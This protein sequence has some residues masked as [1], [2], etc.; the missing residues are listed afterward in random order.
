MNDT[1]AAK[2]VELPIRRMKDMKQIRMYSN[3]T[4]I[5]FLSLLSPLTFAATINVPADQPTIQSGIDAAQNGDTVLVGDG[6]YRGEGN[7]NLDF[8]G[9]EITLKSRNGAEDTI[10]DCE[11][12]FET[13]GFYFHNGETY[14]SV[15]DGFTITNG[16]HDFGGAIALISASPTIK[17]CVVKDNLTSGIHCIN[18]DLS[19]TDSIISRNSWYRCSH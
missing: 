17:N 9:K 14:E 1:K 11:K 16:L 15:L 2:T 7:V 12:K 19:I 13:R 3:L 4:F 10:I 18:S 8:K 6:I 5:V